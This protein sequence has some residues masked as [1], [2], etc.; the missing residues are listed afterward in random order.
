MEHFTLDAGGEPLP[1]A[2][3][4][5][6]TRWFETADRGVAR[7]TVMPNVLVLTTF[8]G[9]VEMPEG[10]IPMLFETRVF[11]GVLDAEE[12]LHQTREA[13]LAGHTEL[14]G[15]CR[16]GNSTDSGMRKEDLD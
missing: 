12:I 13:A 1:E 3:I 7:T 14:V 2:D 10:G 5:A 4:E 16:M 15:W 9:V 11:G 8:S 6:W